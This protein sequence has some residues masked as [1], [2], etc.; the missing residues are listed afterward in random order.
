MILQP[1]VEGQGD[2]AAVPVLLRRLGEIAGAH[3]MR[4]ARPHRHPRN[5]LVQKEPLQNFVR[6]ACLTS[7]CDGVLVLFDADDDCPKELAPRLQSWAQDAAGVVPC[8]VVLANREFEAW[9]LGSIAAM[10][11]TASVRDDALAPADPESVRDAKGRLEECLR[12]D[13]GY[14]PTVDQARLTARLEPAQ[15]WRACRSFRKLVAAFG[16]LLRVGGEPGV[17]WPPETWRAGGG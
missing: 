4:V 8:V 14:S 12:G 1:I 16:A 13:V 17:P 15:A 3:S 5:Q 11:G 2:V 7:G 10:R 9:L 6:V